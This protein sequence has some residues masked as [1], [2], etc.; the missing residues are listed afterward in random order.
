MT[1]ANIADGAVDDG[2]QKVIVESVYKAMFTEADAVRTRAQS[3]YTIA[4]AI[5][6]A[7]VTAGAL[8]DITD[9][10]PIVQVLAAL[11]VASW[12]TTAGLFLWLTRRATTA[13]SRP[14]GGTDGDL[15]ATQ[16]IQAA[17]NGPVHEA[18]ALE[19]RLT[20][21]V[22]AAWVALAAT[23][24]A[25]CAGLIVE[26]PAPSSNTEVSVIR[27]NNAGRAAVAEVCG[28]TGSTLEATLDLD[29]LD[30]RY[31]VIEVDGCQPD[32]TQ[33]TEIRIPPKGIEAVASEQ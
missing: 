11:A 32:A 1:D 33:A 24:A 25:L 3:A 16:F 27:L 2:A 13:F 22:A 14:D 28:L 20:K 29:T 7:I 10:S 19:G 8:T 23:A 26:A 30:D 6:A 31:A 12:L 9:M 5:A 15:D 4:S 21:A 18:R 17:V